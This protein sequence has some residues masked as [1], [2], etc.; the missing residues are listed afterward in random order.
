MRSWFYQQVQAKD[1]Y[2]NVEKNL[3]DYKFFQGIPRV[4]Q[5]IFTKWVIK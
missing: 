2:G 3:N 4:F 5:E 1:L